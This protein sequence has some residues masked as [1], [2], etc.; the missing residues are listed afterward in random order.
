MLRIMQV[1][2]N[3]LLTL[4]QGLGKIKPSLQHKT[5]AVQESSGRLG[6]DNSSLIF[7]AF[8]F[9]LFQEYSPPPYF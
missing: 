8:I 9:I 4:S 7:E 1:I 6:I 3:I 2:K 5:P